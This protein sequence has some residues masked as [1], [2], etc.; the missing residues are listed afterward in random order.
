MRTIPKNNFTCLGC[1]R[2]ADVAGSMTEPHS[3]ALCLRVAADSREEARPP[4]QSH[5]A[6][7]Y[8]QRDEKES[9]HGR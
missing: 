6:A 2:I 8:V 3:R 4:D 1:G 5:A 9:R 7:N